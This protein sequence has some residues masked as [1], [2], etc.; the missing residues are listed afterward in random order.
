MVFDGFPFLRQRMEFVLLIRGSVPPG[1]Q[2]S[3]AGVRQNVFLLLHLLRP[4]T[5]RSLTLY[6]L[7]PFC[8][9]L[10]VNFL[11]PYCLLRMW[12]GCPGR[13][14]ESAL[15]F[16]SWKLVLVFLLKSQHP[17]AGTF[18]S[19]QDGIPILLNCGAFSRDRAIPW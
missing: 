4:R 19:S 11:T 13:A 12:G 10:E 8:V 18:P 14:P 16:C 9:I 15:S 2:R 7:R 5:P 6:C 17:A 1:F 3:L